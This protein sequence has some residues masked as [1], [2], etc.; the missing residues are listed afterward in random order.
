MHILKGEFISTIIGH[1]LLF[2]RVVLDNCTVF[3]I[4]TTLNNVPQPSQKEHLVEQ[5]QAQVAVTIINNKQL[6]AQA[7]AATNTSINSNNKQ[8]QVTAITM[9]S[10]YKQYAATCTW[11]T[12]I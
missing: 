3:S 5:Q 6:Q 4:L 10:K 1:G 12:S 2:Q 7:V 9:S 8:Q 11:C